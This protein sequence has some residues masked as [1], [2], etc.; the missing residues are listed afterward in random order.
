MGRKVTKPNCFDTFLLCFG[1]APLRNCPTW[2]LPKKILSLCS[3]SMLSCLQ[4]CITNCLQMS[5][6]K[7]GEFSQFFEK[8]SAFPKVFFS[9]HLVT[10]KGKIDFWILFCWLGYISDDVDP[11]L[12]TCP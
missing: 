10:I 12:V 5:P 1:M 2:K 6:N 4:S 9:R 11:P 7:F 3:E 8:I